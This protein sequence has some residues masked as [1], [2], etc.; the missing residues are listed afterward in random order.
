MFCKLPNVRIWAASHVKVS[1]R[2]PWLNRR[3]KRG[4]SPPNAH[5]H[6]VCWPRPV[7]VCM[8]SRRQ[9]MHKTIASLCVVCACVAC[10]LW[11][12]W[13]GHVCV[14]E[15]VCLLC[16]RL[17]LVKHA[18]MFFSC[19]CMHV[20]ACVRKQW[21]CWP[22]LCVMHCTGSSVELVV[23]ELV[24][25]NFP[26][27]ACMCALHYTCTALVVQQNLLFTCYK[28]MTTAYMFCS[29][30]SPMFW[31][32]SGCMQPFLPLTAS[33]FFTFGPNMVEF[34]TLFFRIWSNGLR[35]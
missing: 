34:R 14:Y 15:F 12:W 25:L 1:S 35:T 3:I 20:F 30:S 2:I 13:P 10:T 9:I 22:G 11:I 31:V 6:W 4:P 29:L 8:C 21:E 19:A 17:W 23:S 28:F 26:V 18:H 32:W 33:F 24:K 27:Y 7:C 16:V 5:M